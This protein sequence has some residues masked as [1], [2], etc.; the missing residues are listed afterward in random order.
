MLHFV[1]GLPG[2]ALPADTPSWK[3]CTS[4]KFI[5]NDAT[6]AVET[7]TAARPRHADE[8]LILK[9]WECREEVV[10]F[11]AKGQSYAARN[12][13]IIC[14]L[15]RFEFEN[16]PFLETGIISYSCPSLE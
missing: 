7:L 14:S 6:H 13:V 3:R 11:K 4:C 12:S 8:R 15:V 9:T 1:T 5:F 10:T 16:M 2:N